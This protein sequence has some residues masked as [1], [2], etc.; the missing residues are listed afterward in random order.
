MWLS[1]FAVILVLAIT[2]YQALHGLFSSVIMCFL[3]VLS[4][5]LAFA[6]YEPIYAS[7]LV[8]HQ[9]EH[10][11]AI[12]LMGVFIV[13][14]LVLRTIVDVVIPGNMQFNQHVDRFVG[15]AFG[16]VTAM[17]IVGMLATSLQMLPFGTQVLGFCRYTLV[18]ANTGKTLDQEIGDKGKTPLA[19]VNW[20][21][22]KRSRQSV[23][24][25]P[26]GFTVGLMSFLSSNAL[27]LPGS[28]SLSE[29]H[30]KLL[31]E[32]HALRAHPFGQTRM[33]APSGAIQKVEHVWNFDGPLY[34]REPAKDRGRTIELKP[35][36][37]KPNIGMKW[38]GLRVRFTNDARDGDRGPFR[39]T[40]EQIV[41]VTKDWKSW[42]TPVGMSAPNLLSAYMLLYPGEP[43]VFATKANKQAN[44]EKARD[45]VL[46]FIFEVPEED[47]S[48]LWFI[49]FK[50]DARKEIRLTE[51]AKPPLPLVE[52]QVEETKPE[53]A[54][55]DPKPAKNTQPAVRPKPA[56]P[57][58]NAHSSGNNSTTPGTTARPAQ[59]KGKIHGFNLGA[60]DPF[61]GDELPFELT[62]YMIRNQ[63]LR[64]G[65]L[66]GGFLSAP[67]D[68]EWK[69]RE[70][71]KRPLSRFNVPEGKQLLQ[72]YVDKLD[73]ESQLGTWLA[74]AYANVQNIFVIDDQS[75]TYMPVGAYAMA[76]VGR[77]N[78][79]DLIYLDEISRD[80]RK[81]PPFT[82]IKRYHLKGGGDHSFVFLFHVP[83]GRTI[84]EFNTA[85]TR[86][87]LRPFDLTATR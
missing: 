77:Q 58:N 73:T 70:G 67:L 50:Q 86:I 83:A 61:L 26:D 80:M 64:G 76:K 82:K 60:N 54:K 9:P 35:G 57:P 32:L 48:E 78:V 6:L 30:P 65:K 12:A 53:P 71:T 40:P 63:E 44:R 36:P 69:P 49:Q 51:D 74:G 79:F 15:G 84:V 4:A 56:E 10:G 45:P 81:L 16:L 43:I 85:K 46:D 8:D 28:P 3:T 23:M 5:A 13:T 11:R 7:F 41:L 22:V 55:P 59:P 39:F 47:L 31:D 37:K 75:Q 52:P 27:H 14:L 20:V 17:V 66:E 38:L 87:D 34:E 24:F 19:N 72:L 21:D 1:F 62:H 68:E 18:D 42:F 2:F 25:N 29:A 33:I